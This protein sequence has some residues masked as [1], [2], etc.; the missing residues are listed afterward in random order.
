MPVRQQ[1]DHRRHFMSMRRGMHFRVMHFFCLRHAFQHQHHGA[2]HGRH[3]DRLIRR[4]QN[5]HRLLHQRYT[6][7]RNRVVESTARGIFGTGRSRANRFG[8]VT[9]PVVDRSAVTH[10]IDRHWPLCAHR[11]FLGLAYHSL[12]LGIGLL[13]ARATVSPRSPIWPLPRVAPACTRQGWPQ[14]S[15]HH[16]PVRRVGCQP[17][18]LDV[19]QKRHAPMPISLP[20]SGFACPAGPA[21]A[22]A[23]RLYTAV[24][25]VLPA[26][27][28][29]TLP[30]CTRAPVPAADAAVLEPPHPPPT[31]SFRFLQLPPAVPKTTPQRPDVLEFQEENRIN[32]RALIQGKTSSA[33]KSVRLA[34]AGWTKQWLALRLPQPCQRP[35][36]NLARYS[37]HASKRREAVAADGQP[38]RPCK[39]PVANPASGR[40]EDADHGVADF[41]EPPAH[42]PPQ[43]RCLIAG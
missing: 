1:A 33:V 25:T 18:C 36:A 14:W 26:A 38:A 34:M 8:G 29:S 12:E 2:A 7:R 27:W 39:Q 28:R 22:L 9:P 10:G 42:P 40:E 43:S 3:I 6:A 19:W 37:M 5:Q 41:R 24:A 16:L 31:H 11:A 21:S 32:Q 17:G 13:A 4:I 30:G 23:E 20:D 35:P 15:I